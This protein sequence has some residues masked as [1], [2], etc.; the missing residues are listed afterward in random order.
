M[1]TLGLLLWCW[2]LAV[3]DASGFTTLAALN[4][5]NNRNAFRNDASKFL[6]QWHDEG[7]MDLYTFSVPGEPRHWFLDLLHP[8]EWERDWQE[9]PNRCRTVFPWWLSYVGSAVYLVCLYFGTKA[10]E[11][12]KPFDLKGLLAGWNLLLAVFSFIGM[13]RCGL[14]FAMVLHKYG[15]EYSICR[16][17]SSSY[18]R[19]P[20][21]FWTLAFVFSKFFE[22]IDTVFLVVRK[23]KVGFLH[24][25]HHFT[26]MMYCW[27]SYVYEM[28]TGIWFCVMNY[29]VHSVMYWYYFLAAI[30]KPPSWAFAVTVLQLSQMFI[31]CYITV[32]HILKM[33]IYPVANCDG[34]MPNLIAAGI[35]Y[36]S[37]FYLFA[38]FMVKRYCCKRKQASTKDKK[39]Q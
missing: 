32:S 6:D 1:V 24:W 38:E 10:M 26:V 2:G 30:G 22:L 31:G 25:Y 9:V 3:A 13:I 35:M 20:V 39:K 4:S 27:N 11:N 15:F 8:F 17:A 19:G 34:Y 37:Y 7:R 33:T 14:H 12:R 28:P 16:A 18:G 23:K 21:G 5:T 29:T 36:A